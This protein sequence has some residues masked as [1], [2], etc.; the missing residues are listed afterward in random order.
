MDKQEAAPNG[1]SI[2]SAIFAQLNLVPNQHAHRQ[3]HGLRYIQ[4]PQQQA[5]SLHYMQVMRPKNIPSVFQ[6]RA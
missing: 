2:D 1:T 5:A 3:T 6:M 4:C